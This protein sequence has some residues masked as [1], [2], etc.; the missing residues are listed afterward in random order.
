MKTIGVI[1]DTHGLIR[2]ELKE[3]LKTCDLIL[4]AGDF[5]QPQ[6][7]EELKSLAPVRCC[8]GNNDGWWA[9]GIP[10]TL[11][12]E[13]FGMKICLSHYRNGLPSELTPFDLAVFGHSHRYLEERIG[14]TLLLNPGSCGPRRFALPVTLAKLYIEGKNIS[15]ERIEL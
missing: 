10:Y 5:C 11:T 7:L 4:H 1:A 13:A 2:P 3:Q 12:T 15:V 14:N 9:D 6:V 8:R